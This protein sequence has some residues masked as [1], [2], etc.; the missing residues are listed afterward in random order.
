MKLSKEQTNQ[1][2]V[3]IAKVYF[4]VGKNNARTIEECGFNPK[5]NINTLCK[6]ENTLLWKSTIKELEK[7]KVIKEVENEKREKFNINIDEI[8]SINIEKLNDNIK[9]ESE[10]IYLTGLPAIETKKV[11]EFFGNYLDRSKKKVNYEEIAAFNLLSSIVTISGVL[12][13]SIEDKKS[14]ESKISNLKLEDELSRILQRC[15]ASYGNMNEYINQKT[16]Y[17]YDLKAL[18]ELFKNNKLIE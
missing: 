5:I 11:A 2:I 8:N 18:Q 1:R 15:I 4:S 12:R 6:Y 10:G 7:E 9:N 14:D 13:K 16:E 3:H 17:L